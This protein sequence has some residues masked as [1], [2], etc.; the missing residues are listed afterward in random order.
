MK[1]YLFISLVFAVSFIGRISAQNISDR[2]SAIQLN[3]SEKLPEADHVAHIEW[4]KPRLEYTNSVENKVSIEAIIQSDRQPKGIVLNVSNKETGKIYG[5]KKIDAPYKDGKVVLKQDIHL[6]DGANKIELVV[7]SDQNVSVSSERIMLIGHDVIS[8][9]IAIDRK[10]YALIFATDKYDYW[11]DL[12]NPVDDARSIAAELRERYGFETEVVENPTMEEVWTK[13]R[14][15]SERKFKPQDQLLIFFAGHGHFDD[16][17]GEGYVVA[18]NSLHNDN[19]RSSY[20]SHNRLRG[21]IN[22]IPCEHILLT[23]DVCFGGTFDQAIARSRS[24]VENESS[25]SEMLVRKFGQKTRKFIT[26][27]GKEYVSDGIP[28]K[29]SPFAG[30]LIEVLRTNGGSDQVLTMMELLVAMEKLKQVPRTGSFGDDQP[31]SDFVFVAKVAS[32]R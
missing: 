20:I 10:D 8:D 19:A 13:I 6:Q 15:Y 31:L 2:T 5:S 3:L 26:S 18:R 1:K 29:H 21:V 17:F 14:A 12:V 11:D 30:K 25:V 22:N 7:I 24:T 23:M 4:I 32:D 16:T 28:G 27:G 9:A